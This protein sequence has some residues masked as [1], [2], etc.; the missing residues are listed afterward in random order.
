[1]DYFLVIIGFLLLILGVD[2][3]LKSSVAI[4]LRLKIPKIIIGMTIISFITSAPELLI[5]IKAALRGS[6]DLALGNVIG[7]NIANIGLVLGITLLFSSIIINKKYF[8]FYWSIMMFSSALLYLLLVNNSKISHIEGGILFA[9]L[10]LFLIYSF[11]SQNNVIPIEYEEKL[12]VYKII[13]FLIIGASGLWFGSSLLIKSATSLAYNF[14]ISERIIGITLFSIGTSVPE[15]AT[16][17]IAVFKKEK[18]ISIGNILGSNIFNI[19]AVLGITSV[20]KPINVTDEKLIT[21]DIFWM[22]AMCFAILP[23]AYISKKPQLN[24]KDGIVLLAFY[25]FFIL[26]AVG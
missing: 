13:F 23:L 16:S 20:I 8:Q 11:R 2:W 1:M 10:C 18:G 3:L 22:F 12:S 14:G 15:L 4:S 19:L 6:S 9:F 24:W 25:F 17:I 21:D 5:S 7:S 26:C